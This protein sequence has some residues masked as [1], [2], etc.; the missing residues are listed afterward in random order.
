[1]AITECLSTGQLL[2]HLRHAKTLRD[3]KC[4]KDCTLTFLKQVIK[5]AKT[6]TYWKK[7]PSAVYEPYDKLGYKSVQTSYELAQTLSDPPS[8]RRLFAK[9][10]VELT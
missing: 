6:V 8:A 1:M 2:N 10:R 7:T 3:D 4:A 5:G 9:G